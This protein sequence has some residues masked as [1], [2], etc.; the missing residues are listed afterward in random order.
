M[1]TKSQEKRKKKSD[2]EK[3]KPKN[4]SDIDEMH[5]LRSAYRAKKEMRHKVMMMGADRM[6]TLT[7]RENISDRDKF[8]KCLDRFRRR[9][10]RQ[11]PGFQTVIV[12]ELQERGAYH[13]HLALNKFYNVNLLRYFWREAICGNGNA[14]GNDSPGNIDMTS[15]GKGNYNRSKIA[16]Y[17]SK[18]MGKE[19]L[20]LPAGSKR[21]MT[22]GKIPAPKKH[23]F[24]VSPTFD[25]FYQIKKLL[26]SITQKRMRKFFELPPSVFSEIYW[27]SSVGN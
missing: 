24:Y 17:L 15:P 16:H 26:E 22:W 12:L 9:C 18:Y 19:E 23:V 11:W 5:R 14:S 6:L 3:E 8:L 20:D 27:F 13:A 10:A 21:Y 7:T 25:P 2:D 4:R 1:L